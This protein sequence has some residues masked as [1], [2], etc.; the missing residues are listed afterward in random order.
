MMLNDYSHSQNTHNLKFVEFESFKIKNL[1][2]TILKFQNSFATCKQGVM[3]MKSKEN[4][5]FM[6]QEHNS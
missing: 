5:Y 1:L 4:L 6:I 2:N 3:Y